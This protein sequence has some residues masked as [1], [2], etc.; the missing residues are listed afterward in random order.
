M[1]TSDY[2]EDAIL[3]NGCLSS[4]VLLLPKL[5]GKAAL[6]QMVRQAVN[7]EIALNAAQR[8]VLKLCLR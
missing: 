7:S 6:A 4:A 5:H 8:P 3:R 2:T 1:F